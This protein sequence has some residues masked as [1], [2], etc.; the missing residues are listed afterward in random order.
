MRHWGFPHEQENYPMY[1]FSEEFRQA[2]ESLTFPLVID[3]F[4][5]EK[6]VPLLVSDG[7]CELTGLDRDKAMTSWFAAGMRTATI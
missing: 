5:D 2:Y 4:I 6:V 3:Q 1:H 7:F